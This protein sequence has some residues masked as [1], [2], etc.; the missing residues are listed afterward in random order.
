MDFT[1]LD[2]FEKANKLEDHRDIACFFYEV[3][4]TIDFPYTKALEDE[5]LLGIIHL[6]N[7]AQNSDQ[8]R[9]LFRAARSLGLNIQHTYRRRNDHECVLCRVY[10]DR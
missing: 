7:S 5:L 9:R 4:K 1:K 8:L 3:G 2:T 10:C 6:A